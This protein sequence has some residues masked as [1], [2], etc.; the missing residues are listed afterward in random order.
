MQL[1]P[2]ALKKLFFAR[3]KR[4]CVVRAPV[5][6]HKTEATKEKF[7]VLLNLDDGAG[8]PLFFFLTS[9]KLA[10]FERN[11]TLKAEAVFIEPGTLGFFPLRTVI[12]CRELHSFPKADIEEL[13]GQRRIEVVGDLL[14]AIMAQI[15]R[16][17][18]DS[19]LISKADKKRILPSKWA[20]RP[21]LPSV[22]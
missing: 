1:P 3:L 21:P 10:F 17:V 22:D 6:F 20:G 19:K 13:A 12:N 18:A 15:D 9:S 8:D 11:P 5:H 14:P 4:G 2:E 7:L 16:I